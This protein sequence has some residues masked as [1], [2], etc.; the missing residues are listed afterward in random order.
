M[1]QRSISSKR[2]VW[3]AVEEVEREELLVRYLPLL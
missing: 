2:M 3:S 1:R